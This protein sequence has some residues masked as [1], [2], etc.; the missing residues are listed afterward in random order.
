MVDSYRD[1]H[2]LARL[3]PA[4]SGSTHHAQVMRP[5]APFGDAFKLKSWERRVVG[6][7]HRDSHHLA[8]FGPMF[9]RVCQHPRERGVF[10]DKLLV[11]IHFIVE[12]IWW[13][14]LAP[15]EF[16]LHP[17]S[18]YEKSPAL[19]V[20]LY[21][22]FGAPWFAL[23]VARFRRAPGKIKENEKCDLIQP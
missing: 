9:D 16:E 18:T 8:R 23:Q 19:T 2:H 12:M 4:Y 15:Q 14:G 22:R 3:R 20:E 1:S 10:V 21:R 11:R 13:T 5:V 6:E 7:N 17:S